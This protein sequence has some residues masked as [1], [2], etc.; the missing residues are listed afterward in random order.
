[1]SNTDIDYESAVDSVKNTVTRPIRS[2]SL[3][4]SIYYMSE[5]E[6]MDEASFDLHKLTNDMWDGFYYYGMMVL[7]REAAS[8]T[9]QFHINGR[10]P[11]AL[12]DQKVHSY[13]DDIIETGDPEL[14]KE[15]Y[16]N[17]SRILS[18]VRRSRDQI[19][20][21]LEW[22]EERHQ[23][24]SNEERIVKTCRD[25]FD[26]KQRSEDMYEDEWE[27]QDDREFTGWIEEFG[28]QLW[29]MIAQHILNRDDYT[30]VMWV[31]QSWAI[32]HNG[33]PWMDKFGH[34][35]S[36]D[37]V[38]DDMSSKIMLS[39]RK[40]KGKY[41]DDVIFRDLLKRILDANAME[42]IGKVLMWAINYESEVDANIGRY[43]RTNYNQ[44]W[45]DG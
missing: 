19:R 10:K 37:A 12:D 32:Q 35:D 5:I 8:F 34:S 4:Y 13:L 6:G 27:R 14:A 29:R 11:S 7:F 9:T 16:A 38:V 24:L 41:Y 22:M 42:D 20:A 3:F 1:M 44:K 18:N 43:Y 30:K 21:N 45:E 15:I 2:S 17:S 36:E 33:G 31:D 40:T 28:G 25:L 23:A 26:Q 39:S